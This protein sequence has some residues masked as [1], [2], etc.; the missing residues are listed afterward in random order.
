M[1]FDTAAPAFLPDTTHP[2]LQPPVCRFEVI[3]HTRTG[4]VQSVA[5]TAPGVG[6]FLAAFA[7]IARGAVLETTHGQVAIE[8]VTPGDRIMTSSGR[9]EQVN[10]RGSVTLDPGAM[11]EPLSLTRVP[12]DAYGPGRPATDTL[13]GPGAIRVHRAA[14]VCARLSAKA[15]LSPLAEFADDG[16]MFPITPRAAVEFFQLGFARQSGLLIGGVEVASLYAAQPGL[17]RMTPTTRAAYQS[18]FP[19]FLHVEA[20]GRA[21]GPT[22]SREELEQMAA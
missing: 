18:L 3:A 8:D 10:W 19:Q 7:V 22:L 6:P 17:D 11:P 16:A 12:V 9:V 14:S 13:F 2:N 5:R 4:L 15:V 20:A 1:I 21:L